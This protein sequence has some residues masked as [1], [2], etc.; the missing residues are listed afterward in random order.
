MSNRD[1]LRILS[2]TKELGAL[3]RV[4]LRALLPFVDEMHVSAGTRLALEG[5]FCDLFL[6]VAAGEIESCRRGSKGKLE[7]GDTAGWNAM[8]NRSR[9]DA[10]LVAATNAR[11][12]VMSHSQFRAIRAL[13]A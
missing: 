9:H 7:S 1:R 4:Q 10:T 11:L 13:F 2:S 6:I 5:R 12:L 8:H 3:S